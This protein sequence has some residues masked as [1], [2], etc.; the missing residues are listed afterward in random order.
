MTEDSHVP[1]LPRRAQGDT[2]GRRTA[3]PVAPL[4][5]PESVIQQIL[6]VLDVERAEA[7]PQDHPA[8]AEL[9]AHNR[10]ALSER[11]ASLPRRVPGASH[12]GGPPVSITRPELP[13]SLPRSPSVEA[14]TEPL[15]AIGASKASSV[16]EGHEAQLD[17]A[18]QPEAAAAVPAARKLAPALRAPPQK[19][20]GRQDRRDQVPAVPEKAPASQGK[21]QAR[22]AKAPTQPP[23]PAPSMARAR[24]RRGTSYGLI[25]MAILLC[26]S[27]A[28]VLT[29]HAI[30]ATGGESNGTG[31]GADVAIRDRAVAWVAD[32]VSR[33]SIVSCDRVMC[34][35]LAAHGVPAASLLELEPGTA[36]PLRSSI[37]VS[38]AAVRSMIGSRVV[39]ADAPA[40]IASFGS[41]SRQI[42]IRV[43][44]QRGA[45]T[46]LSA[47]ST[48]MLARKASGI[49]LLGNQR[50]RVS[51]IARRQL[52]GGRVDSR[53]LAVI[54]GLVAHRP[55]SIVVFGDLA[56]GASP[57][58]P[59][60]SADLAETAGAG[61]S[62]AAQMP[63]MVA[64]L[65]AQ[66]DPFLAAHIQT[67]RLAAG[68]SVLR[69]EFAAPSV[70]GLL[71]PRPPSG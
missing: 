5:L 55:L 63:W 28:L 25:L 32:Q 12:R 59:L 30:T 9:T 8:R 43:V 67:V 31:T 53:L 7:S 22:Q 51:A 70:L 36:D 13:P 60:R 61:R 50:I 57:G 71:G 11:P 26:G 20:P 3:R 65:R 35:A 37:I 18:A 64:F 40:V 34:Q 16:T 15:P 33:A 23:K 29:R 41:G 44:A 17:I 6:S 47:L 19:R 14:I 24:G 45:A 54:A 56:P 1:P 52:V 21:A 68:R 49:Q 42:S 62:P 2:Q 39:T 4:V 10:A 58:I 48:D 38:T 46:Y 66:R 69:I 27:L